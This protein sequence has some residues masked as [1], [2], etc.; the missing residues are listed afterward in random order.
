MGGGGEKGITQKEGKKELGRMPPSDLLPSSRCH[1]P[2]SL[3]SCQWI[4]SLVRSKPSYSKHYL[5]TLPLNLAV[6]GTMLSIHELFGEH[7]QSKP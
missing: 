3:F 5:K 7:F 6:L 2:S 1:P 4:N